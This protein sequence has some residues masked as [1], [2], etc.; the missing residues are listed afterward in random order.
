MNT[1]AQSDET[2][3]GAM[4]GDFVARF[5]RQE[6]PA[7][8]CHEAKRSLLNFFG[9]ALASAR[10]PAVETAIRVLRPFSGAGESSLI[11]RAERLDAMAA[12]FVNA[13]AANLLDYDDTHLETVIHPTAPVAPPL[14][15]LA[16][17][18]GLPGAE[19]LHAFLL[20]AEVECR[21]GNSVSPGHYAR[22][23]HITATCGVFGAA[24]ACARLLGLD[25]AQ[26]W[27]ALGIAASQAAGVVE[28]LP[29]AAKNVG[30]GNAARNG[31][32]AALLAQQG[33]T[34][35][36]AA[37]EGPLGW[38][39]AAG[40]AP[41]LVAIAEGLGERWEIMKNTY[42]PYPCGIV[43]HAVIDAC[44]DLRTRHGLSADDVAAAVVR[45][46]P[47]LLA[48]GDRPV[49]NERE[50]RVSIHHSVAVAVA[51]G[52]TGVREFSL[53]V[54]TDPAIAALRRKVRAE[55]DDA[56]PVGAAAVEVQTVGGGTLRSVVTHARGS[57]E[58]PLSDQELEAKFAENARL[59][60][61][62]GD[63]ARL[64]EQVWRL[65]EASGVGPL[66]DLMSGRG[67]AGG[68]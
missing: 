38:A 47:L 28:N 17:Q 20:G 56:L 61:F 14:L 23:W 11:G 25:G 32:F 7:A 9:C 68:G 4:L 22:G 62:A 55:V 63:P 45:G 8:L 59:G 66:M 27:H 46:H 6:V 50:A 37:I 30:V 33:Y 36:P 34:A 31:L 12:S 16:E 51:F 29:S 18:R 67:A 40:D 57:R 21:I 15:A 13:V 44:L 58:R 39:R 35:A 48:R 19:V 41:R 10:D 43:L 1:W 2:F 49:E 64:T 60:G 42:K 52:V 65:D 24:A 26:T 53:P 3:V 54:V 5:P